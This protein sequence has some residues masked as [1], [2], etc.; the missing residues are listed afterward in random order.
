VV[1]DGA[2]ARTAADAAALAGAAEGRPAAAALA[3]VNG[4]RLV[5]YRAEG[6]SV[7]VTVAVGRARATARARQD[8]T[9]CTTEGSSGGPI[10][11][12]EPPCPS[13]PG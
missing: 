1:I 11:Y 8:G 3:R 7:V 10:S 4:G 9:W 13:T 2:R 5:A 12:T 6:P